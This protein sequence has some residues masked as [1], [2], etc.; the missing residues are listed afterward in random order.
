MASATT[1]VAPVITTVARRDW[2]KVWATWVEVHSDLGG[3]HPLGAHGL[4]AYPGH[5][6]GIALDDVDTHIVQELETLLITQG[7]GA[8]AADIQDHRD[9]FSVGGSSRHLHGL[10]HGHGEGADVQHQSMGQ[11]HH[12]RHLFRGV[13]HN[14][15]GP[16]DLH[17]VGAVI[18]GH[19][20]GEVVDHRLFRP[21][22]TQQPGH[23]EF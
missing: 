14:R 15:G 19:P 21:D 16:Q 1:S 7:G 17:D 5:F 4:A 23:I 22:L 20:V 3:V 10:H 12:L 18:N 13:G 8:G 11:L 6:R 2:A 9:A